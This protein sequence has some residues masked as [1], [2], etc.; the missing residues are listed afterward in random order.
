MSPDQN[1]QKVVDEAA[2]LMAQEADRSGALIEKAE[3]M[4]RVN[5]RSEEN[6]VWRKIA[7]HRRR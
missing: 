7:V 6:A 4:S 1:V 3:A 5:G 2:T